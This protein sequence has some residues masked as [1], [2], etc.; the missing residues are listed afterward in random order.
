MYILK[1]D[2]DNIGLFFWNLGC[3]NRLLSTTVE[4]VTADCCLLQW[5]LWQLT[6][7][8]YSRGCDSW[9]ISPTVEAVKADC[10]LLQWRLRQ[11]QGGLTLQPHVFHSNPT[12][13][14]DLLNGQRWLWNTKQTTSDTAFRNRLHRIGELF[15]K[16]LILM[17][18][19]E[20]VLLHKY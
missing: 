13:L 8:S 17:Q 1:P 2:S 4:A 18:C 14:L 16:E 7:V 3:D 11:L 12:A 9:L 20:V 5:R 19:K 15:P 10:C 6:A